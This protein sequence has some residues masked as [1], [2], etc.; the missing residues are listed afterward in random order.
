MSKVGIL[1]QMELGNLKMG[2]IRNGKLVHIVVLFMRK[3]L[4]VVIV[5]N[6]IYS[7]RA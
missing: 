1:L 6:D 5:I 2:M 4:C 3:E 7:L